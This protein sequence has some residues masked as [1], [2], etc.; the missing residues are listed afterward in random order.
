MVVRILT[1]GDTDGIC[2]AAMARARFPDAEIWFSRP[3]RLLRYLNDIELGTIVMI[4]DIAI[5][6]A[7][8]EQIF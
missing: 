7:N 5:N 2:A 6:E 1:H 8:K 3:V 4:F